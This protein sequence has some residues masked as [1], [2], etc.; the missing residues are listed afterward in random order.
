MTRIGRWM[1]GAALLA[2]ACHC[3]GPGAPPVVGA[4]SGA[5]TPTCDGIRPKVERLYRAEAQ[6]KEPKRVDEAVADNTAMVMGDCAKAPEK[7]ATCVTEVAS[8]AD[9]EQK[10]LAALDDEGSEGEALKR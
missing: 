8:V 10:C 9:L 3:S 5:V 2:A 1:I 6:V 7:V 4:G